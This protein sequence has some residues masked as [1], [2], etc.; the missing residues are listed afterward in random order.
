MSLGP[1]GRLRLLQEENKQLK[2]EVRAKD[3]IMDELMGENKV[4]KECFQD[5]IR[6]FCIVLDD[7]RENEEA[8]SSAATADLTRSRLDDLEVAEGPDDKERIA[9]GER[10][11]FVAQCCQMFK[12]AVSQTVL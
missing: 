10:E 11:S 9:G 2:D 1:L 12:G 8:G 3:K 5:T 7:V 6:H 4:L